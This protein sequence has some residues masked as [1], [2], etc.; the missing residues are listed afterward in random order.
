MAVTL[1][2]LLITL[3]F[4]TA[5]TV[6]GVIG[7]GLPTVA[8]GI[9]GV[10]MPPVQAAALLI[11]PSLVTNIWQLCSG[12]HWAL[13]CRRLWPMLLAV[14]V[15]T[16]IGAGMITGG[17]AGRASL[18]LGILLVIY[19]LVSLL[20]RQARMTAATE[21][22]LGP[23][24]GFVTG[25]LT[26]ATGVFVIPAAPYLNALAL[27]RDDLIQ[28]LGLS[29]TVSTLALAAGLA[30]HHALAFNA[31][32]LSLLAVIPALAGMF[33]GA[34][35]RNKISPGLFRRCFFLGLLV[36]GLEIAWQHLP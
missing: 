18:W 14:C 31:L 28:A 17:I 23:L 16:W 6:K 33:F 25:L 26:G 11:V 19:A 1:Y 36:L 30:W 22:W 5:G 34:Y 12:S 20:N 32:A 13:L 24:M 3:T 2:F 4:F 15:G 7:L 27:E 21:K 9:L 8:M 29:F 10:V 35:L